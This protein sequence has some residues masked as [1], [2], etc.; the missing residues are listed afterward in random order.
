MNSY[1]EVNEAVAMTLR[2]RR[3]DPA[4]EAVVR[5]KVRGRRWWGRTRPAYESPFDAAREA[6]HDR[7]AAVMR[8]VGGAS[9]PGTRSVA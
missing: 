3:P 9:A 1:S 4:C 7:Q 6:S 5:Q 2:S 8:G